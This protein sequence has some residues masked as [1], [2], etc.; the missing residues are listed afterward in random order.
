MLN[1]S[2]N[3]IKEILNAKL[4]IILFSAPWCGPCRLLTPL[5]DDVAKDYEG[6]AV[7][8]KVNVDDERE[9]ASQYGI[10]SIPTILFFKNGQIV[11]K[12]IGLL[13][14]KELKEKIDR[15]I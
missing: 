3:N 12:Q 1:L 8:A 13:S 5:I 2:E 14:K 15:L 10:M 9:V 7:I 6:K 11:D 4:G